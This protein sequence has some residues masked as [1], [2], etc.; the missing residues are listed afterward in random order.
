[1][2]SP[3]GKLKLVELRGVSFQYGRNVVLD[4]VDL[5]IYENDFLGIIGPNGGGKT[6]LLKLILGLLEPASGSLSVFGKS[7][8]AGRSNIG[9]LPQFSSADFNLP[10]SVLEVVMMSRLSSGAFFKSY[11]KQ[12]LELSCKALE[13]ARALDLKDR[14][15]GDLSGGEKQRV[16]IARALARKPRLLI[17]DE[18]TSNLD[19]PSGVEF[20]ELLK[21]LNKQ[22]AIILISHDIG[23]VSTYVSKV[24]CLNKTLF[25][26]GSKQLTRQ[27]IEKAYGCPIE[28]IAHG[29]P[30]RVFGKHRVSTDD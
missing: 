13:Q 24:A 6:T 16:L 25:Y 8:R 9:S 14:R 28:L 20:Y 3:K 26:H 21:E 22:M 1:M 4:K 10:L 19:L 2:R 7:P 17:L 29:V 11:T 27:D 23:A 30:H 15:F 5:T 18:P 12:D